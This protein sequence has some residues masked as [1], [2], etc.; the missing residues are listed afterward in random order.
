MG[1]SYL[2]DEEVLQQLQFSL[3]HLASICS[4]LANSVST[5][6]KFTLYLIDLLN[7]KKRVPWN[8]VEKIMGKGRENGIWE[9]VVMRRKKEG[10]VCDFDF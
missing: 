10:S 8:I 2:E 4:S 5:N 6:R 7:K 3:V 1:K 9:L